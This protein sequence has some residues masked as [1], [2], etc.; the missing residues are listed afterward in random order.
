MVS[1]T[2]TR[3]HA[4]RGSMQRAVLAV[5]AVHDA[6]TRAMRDGDSGVDVAAARASELR[7]AHFESIAAPLC[8]CTPLS[9]RISPR[10]AATART[11]SRTAARSSHR[12][13]RATCRAPATHRPW[14]AGHCVDTALGGRA[15]RMRTRH[16]RLTHSCRSSR[17]AVM[18]LSFASPLLRCSSVRRLVSA[19]CA[20]VHGR[21]SRVCVFFSGCRLHCNRTLRRVDTRRERVCDRRRGPRLRRPHCE[22]R[23]VGDRAL[24]DRLECQHLRRAAD[25][26]YL[27]VGRHRRVHR[28]RQQHR[29]IRRLP[30]DGR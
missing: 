9:P 3:T 27:R 18:S 30:T 28:E 29:L 6:R 5:R 7:G 25:T 26:A 16:R 15:M 17:R 13:R 10:C 2:H 14:S 21:G 20:A 1:D 23:R 8:V 11:H 22:W 19:Q 4:E 12:R 24:V